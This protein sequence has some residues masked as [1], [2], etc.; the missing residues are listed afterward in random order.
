MFPEHM[1]FAEVEYRR[2]QARAS[3]P[4]RPANSI[5][6]GKSRRGFNF[7]NRQ[8]RSARKTRAAERL[9]ELT[10]TA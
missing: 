3:W 1:V 8:K 2:E 9:P 5:R 4:A 7:W 6:S 10:E